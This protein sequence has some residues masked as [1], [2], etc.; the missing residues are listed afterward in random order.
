VAVLIV[1]PRASRV[2]PALTASVA[3][4]L[5]RAGPLEVVATTGP[6]HARDLAAEA[7]SRGE[8]VYVFSGDGGYNEALNGVGEGPIGFL[9]GGGTNVLPRALGLP[10]DPVECARRLAAAGNPRRISLG[11]VN[12]RR[13]GFA[14]GL[15]LDA[16]AVR[17]VD[18]RGRKPDGR[19]PGDLAFMGA[20]ARLLRA[21]GG[22]IDAQIE[23]AGHG[24]VAWALI[25]KGPVYTYAGPIPVRVARTARFELG[26]DLVA[27][28]AIRAR[29][30]PRL[31]GYALTGR[32]QQHASDIVYVHDADRLELRADRPLPLQADGED[33]GDERE[34]LLEA[35]RNAVAVLVGGADPSH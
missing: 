24:R 8:T 23:V 11:R 18:E 31:M 4:E 12:G 29:S 33:L 25:S 3:R 10:R 1:N 34:V 20:F 9:P 21:S 19:R 2:T 13:F 32:G 26:L 6:W 14:V 16:A 17:A 28:R 35:E 30:F 22:R 7:A 15:G 5:E 27:P